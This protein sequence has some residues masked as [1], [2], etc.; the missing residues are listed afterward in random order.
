MWKQLIAGAAV[1]STSVGVT[2]LTLKNT[3]SASSSSS[4]NSISSWTN[5]NPYKETAGEKL[6]GSLLSYEAMDIDGDITITLGNRN[7]I[8]LKLD[9]Q[10]SIADINDIKILFYIIVSY[11]K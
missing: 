1:F 2:F 10:G 5:N 3:N 6:L 4:A 11:V 9:G 7:Q 8:N